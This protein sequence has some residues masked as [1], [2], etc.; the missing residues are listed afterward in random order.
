MAE[1]YLKEAFGIEIVAFVSSVGKVHIPR[2]AGE[3]LASSSAAPNR[4]QEAS[5]A[6]SSSVD[7]YIADNITEEEADEPLSKEFREL[8]NGVTREVVDQ[9]DIRCPHKEAAE[10]M[11]DVSS[12]EVIIDVIREE[13]Y[14]L[15]MRKKIEG[16]E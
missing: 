6:P 10:R 14:D 4:V 11:R 8:L 15:T 1:K 3:K 9:N 16:K 5:T 2:F 13:R 7:N 12:G